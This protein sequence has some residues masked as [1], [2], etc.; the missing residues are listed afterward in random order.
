MI[1]ANYRPTIGWVEGLLKTKFSS[2]VSSLAQIDRT[3]KRFIAAVV[4]DNFTGTSIVASI[5]IG[6][7]M[8]KR[9]LHDIFDYP[10]N[11]L[12]VNQILGYVNSSN[13]KAIRLNEKLGFVSVAVIPGVYRDGDMII[14]SMSRSDCRLLEKNDG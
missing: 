6:G 11:Q 12:R 3:G 8:N 2:D 13:T 1:V 9:F 14:Y 4:Y 7:A 5:V 10:F